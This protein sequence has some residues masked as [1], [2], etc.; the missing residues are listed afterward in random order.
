MKAVD[1][2]KQYDAIIVGSGP[3]GLAAGIAL[4]QKGKKVKI[5]EAGDTVGGGARTKFLTLPGYK[6]D[7]CS[8]IHPMAMA[9]P[10]FASL[11]LE[12]YGLKWITPPFPVAHP[13]D[14]EP[15]IIMDLDIHKTANELG[16]DKAAYL[17]LLNPIVR[18]FND[19]LPDL[20]GP[21]NPFPKS[22]I[23]V[24][25]FGLNAIRSATSL[26]NSKFDGD[27]SRALFAGLAA[28][29]IQPLDNVA[30]SAIALVLGAAGHAVGWPLPEGG[31]QSLANALADHFAFL[32][33]EIETG[34]LITSVDQLSEAKTILFDITPQQI[35]SIAENEIPK[36]YADKLKDYRYGPGVFKLD[37]ALDG[38]IPWKDENCNNAATVHIGGTFEEIAEAEN[39]VFEGKHPEKPFVLLTQQSLFDK[40]RA[41]EGKH[42]VWCYCHVPNG[43]T[44]DMTLQ[45]ENQIERFAPGFKDLI[46][47]RNKM[48]ASDMQ[49]YNPNY[50]GGDINGGIQ[51]IRQLFTRPVNLFDPYRIPNTSFFICSSSS[52]PGG[53]VHGMC[54]YHAAQAALKFLR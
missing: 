45:I 47:S 4:A 27:R 34:K 28:H 18:D 21:F 22:P 37:L 50:I 49:T 36:S 26:V 23:K 25:K 41:P 24:A 11:P 10:F 46:L 20:L 51:D 39:Q 29:S 3:N 13:L 8:A 33:G 2:H 6:H 40:T 19:L 48:N 43:S 9:S 12:K 32:G 52:P 30:T 35:L 42:T 54:G 17:K 31:S 7:V 44:R 1:K 38:P 16:I 53:G 14:N 5:I 15:A